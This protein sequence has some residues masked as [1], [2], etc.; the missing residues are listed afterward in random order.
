M[1][2][3]FIIT[4]LLLSI[5]LGFGGNAS[6]QYSTI[7]VKAAFLFNFA[8]FT[9]WPAQHGPQQEGELVVGIMGR[10]PFG[11]ALQAFQNKQIL[12]RPVQVRA[13]STLQEARNCHILFIAASEATHLQQV[14]KQ[15]QQP[16]ILTVSD[17]PG[18]ASK[19]GMIELLEID[20][21]IRFAVNLDA[22]RKAELILSAHL[23]KLARNVISAP[24]D[25][26]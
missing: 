4:C 6:A 17:I 22:S 5:F 25:K 7:E 24:E 23:L 15:L 9:S 10:N 2:R 19:G 21:R 18:F 20:Q 12:G 26:P 16:G 3:T 11:P 8:Q 14:L 13:V 1:R